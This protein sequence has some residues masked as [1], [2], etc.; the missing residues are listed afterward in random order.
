MSFV[1]ITN[2]TDIII[3][4]FNNTFIPTF[5]GI[6][7]TYTPDLTYT[8][9]FEDRRSY[10]MSADILEKTDLPAVFWNR[11]TVRK[12]EQLQEK[13]IQC[14]YLPKDL[15]KHDIYSAFFGTIE[16]SFVYSDRTMQEMEAYE[17]IY[18]SNFSQKTTMEIDWGGPLGPYTYDFKF[19]TLEDY[20]I[21]RR[22]VE[23]RLL[24]A[25][26]QI[27]GLFFMVSGEY[28]RLKW[29]DIYEKDFDA[30][31]LLSGTRTMPWAEPRPTPVR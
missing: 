2:I 20:Q 12:H 18:M 10:K 27:S 1:V 28:P 26:V 31:T 16:M 11:S 19:S 29:I 8:T 21:E 13:S 22:S 25:S 14:G 3:E 30:V 15:D 9:G 5:D 17:L 7:L 4:F 23:Y 24:P 6:T